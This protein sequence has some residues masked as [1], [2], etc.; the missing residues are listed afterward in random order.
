MIPSQNETTDTLIVGAGLAG[1]ACARKLHESGKSFVI[2][3]AADRVGGRVATDRCEGYRFDRGFQVL[4]TAYPEAQRL[5]DYKALD[6]RRFYPGA[7]VRYGGTWHQVAD[8]FRH[9]IDGL[10]GVFNPIGTF[11]DKLRI[12]WARLGG[13]DF[14]HRPT[15]MTTLEALRAAG[16]SASMIERFFRPFLGGVFLESQLATTVRKLEFVLRNF[17][18]GHTAIPAL[19]MAEIPNQLAAPLPATAIRLRTRVVAINGNL[20]RLETGETLSAKSV[21]I[22]TEAGGAEHLLGRNDPPADFNSVTCLYF[23][24]PS[25]PLHKPILLLNGEGVGPINNLTVLSAVSPDYAPPGRHLISA[26]VVDPS[27]AAAPDLVEQVRRNLIDWFGEGAKSWELLRSI[28]IPQAVPSQT[29]AP[30]K[31]ARLCKGLYQCGDHCGLA[32]INTALASG[33]VA[34]EALLEDWS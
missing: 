7:L 34:A 16:F 30:V 6:L 9:P 14:S 21:V 25:S 19:G 5:L 1:L 17:A 27:A 18:Q 15:E 13:F 10:R 12:G 11:S 24:A 2:C 20:V 23:D 4:L 26:S 28:R 29:L 31:P 22:A 3:E 8:P 32:S 33:T